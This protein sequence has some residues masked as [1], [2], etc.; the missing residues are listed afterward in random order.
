MINHIIDGLAI[1]IKFQKDVSVVHYQI[2]SKF[3]NNW[4]DLF[5][6]GKF[7]CK[8]K[9]LLRPLQFFKKPMPHQGGIHKARGQILGHFWLQLHPPYV[10]IDLSTK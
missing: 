4:L 10:K 9:I 6:I 8:I 1:L 5:E 3:L 2:N 7:V